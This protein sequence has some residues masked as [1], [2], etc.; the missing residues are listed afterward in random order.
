L[1]IRDTATFSTLAETAKTA[2]AG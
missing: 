1:A 2:L